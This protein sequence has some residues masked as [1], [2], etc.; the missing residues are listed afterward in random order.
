MSF[1]LE[2]PRLLDLYFR[3]AKLLIFP[4]LDLI[5]VYWNNPSYSTEPEFWP[6]EKKKIQEKSTEVSHSREKFPPTRGNIQPTR[7][8]LDQRKKNWFT[9]KRFWPT[10]KKKFDQ[11]DKHF[12]LRGKNDLPG[13]KHTQNTQPRVSRRTRDPR[14]LA[15]LTNVFVDIYCLL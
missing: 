6:V 9:S 11:R 2:L 15:D 14:N 7:N 12:K 5:K 8:I 3:L 10:R 1:S 13:C 4:T